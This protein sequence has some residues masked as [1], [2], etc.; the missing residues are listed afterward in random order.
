MHRR[1]YFRKNYSRQELSQG[2]YICRQCH[3]GIHR[4][5][6]AMELAKHLNTLD[7]LLADDS[8]AAHFAWVARQRIRID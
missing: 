4:F 1:A 6:T 7:R 3:D 8:L 2:I 5:Y